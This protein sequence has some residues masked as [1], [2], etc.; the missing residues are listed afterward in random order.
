M[1]RGK[2][3]KKNRNK[4]Q[5]IITLEVVKTWERST[6]TWGVQRASQ[7][8]AWSVRGAAAQKG[9]FRVSETLKIRAYRAVV[10]FWACKPNPFNFCV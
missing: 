8:H 2:K 7:G 10:K 5:Q 9:N 4:L 3:G 6:R 1:K